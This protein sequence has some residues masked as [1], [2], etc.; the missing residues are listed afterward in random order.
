MSQQ[1]Q[2]PGI[3]PSLTELDNP[4]DPPV[5][6]T[7][8]KP[9]VDPQDDL[10]KNPV[11]TPSPKDPPPP[12]DPKPDPNKPNEGDDDQTGDDDGDEPADPTAFWGEVTKLRGDNLTW[13]FPEDVDP[14]T[15]AGIHHAIQKA[16]DREL[17]IFEENLMKGNP[18]AYAYMLH[19]SNGGTD[20][21]FFSQKTEVLPDLD[22]L[23]GSV[24]LQ[25]AFYKRSLTRKG[26]LPEQADLII[27]DAVDKNKLAGLVEAD[28]KQQ[29]DQQEKHLKE[30]LKA[31]EEAQ[32]REDQ[33]IQ[34]MGTLLQ[35]RIIE[36]KDLGITIPDAKR[37]GFLQFVNNLVVLDKQSG[38]FFIN[39][40]LSQENLSQVL[41]SLYYMHVKGNLDD[42]ISNRAKQKNT[43]GIKL[44]MQSDKTKRSSQVDPNKQTNE[45]PG[46]QPAISEL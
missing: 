36:N 20:E 11:N 21:D 4:A 39:H 41:E 30:L 14:L 38:K 29:A 5:P 10:S 13:E 9:P 12:A 25:S 43:Q 24:D 33:L 17:E 8:Q 40:E 23:K 15:P 19:I 44:R 35:Q 26:I 7:D 3:Q 18:R 27:K 28:Y 16:T 32:K 46:I 42:I 22:V 31:N 34:R 6:P 1:Q 45:K 37:G 2:K